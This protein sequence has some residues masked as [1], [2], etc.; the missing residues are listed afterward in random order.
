M[1][2]LYFSV[3]S[4]VSAYYRSGHR[5][6]PARYLPGYAIMSMKPEQREL[7][8]AATAEDFSGLRLTGITEP[9]PKI[10]PKI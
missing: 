9:W 6:I 5:P 3:V 2:D 7:L 8:K 4:D 10:E 1:Q